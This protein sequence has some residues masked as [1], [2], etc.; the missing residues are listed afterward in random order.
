LCRSSYLRDS[1]SRSRV[2]GSRS[3]EP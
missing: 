1:P 3:V 2:K